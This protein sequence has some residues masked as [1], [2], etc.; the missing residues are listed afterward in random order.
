MRFSQIRDS[1][2]FHFDIVVKR[3]YSQIDVILLR[4]FCVFDIQEMV[5]IFKSYFKTEK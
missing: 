5:S 3:H 2:S 1:L 4:F